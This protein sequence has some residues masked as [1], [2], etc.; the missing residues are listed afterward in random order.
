MAIRCAQLGGTVLFRSKSCVPI[1]GGTLVIEV[2][3]GGE[4]EPFVVRRVD[5]PAVC[6]AVSDVYSWIET[7]FVVH[8][9]VHVYQD[10]STNGPSVQKDVVFHIVTH[11]GSVV[12]ASIMGVFLPSNIHILGFLEVVAQAGAQDSFLS[13]LS[14]CCCASSPPI[15]ISAYACSIDVRLMEILAKGLPVDQLEIIISSIPVDLRSEMDFSF[16]LCLRTDQVSLVSLVLVRIRGAVEGVG[17]IGFLAE[18]ELPVDI[19]VLVAEV[20]LIVDLS[21][22]PIAVGGSAIASSSSTTDSIG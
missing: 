22:L 11:I 4:S 3:K 15:E 13:Q 9:G 20:S 10:A 2:S 7:V 5:F 6:W 21:L 14:S 18:S 8:A 12:V 19:K 17:S 16:R 1:V